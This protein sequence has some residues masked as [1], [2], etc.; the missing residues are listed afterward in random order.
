MFFSKRQNENGERKMIVK[1]NPLLD[2]KIL[3]LPKLR[4][5]ADDKLN[6]TQNVKFVFHR[7]ENNVFK[8]LFPPVR[9]SRGN[10]LTI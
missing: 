8:R 1:I 5:F 7:I 6:V 10:G 4:A 9:Q 3:G 2:D